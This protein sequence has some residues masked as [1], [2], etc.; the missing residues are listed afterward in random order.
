MPRAKQ[1]TPE[2][3][4]D[5]LVAALDVLSAAGPVGVTTRAVAT[6]AGTSVPALYEL[7]GDKAGLVRALFFEG[8]RR[9]GRDYAE[10]APTSDPLADLVAAV[11]TFRAFARANPR[12]FE[13]M[14]ARPFA[15]FSPGPEELATGAATRGAFVGPVQR[16]V[17]RG[18]LVGDATDIAH[19]VL[20]L[21]GGLV[22]Q[23]IAGW[24]GSSPESIERRWQ[25][26]VAAFL[27]GHRPD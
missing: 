19:G 16:A 12:L 25:A 5:L 11:E 7:F 3:R 15:E 1:R 4:A 22:T 17:D 8:F 9:L 13:V 20:A 18:L 14:Y 21:A 2:L 26:S 10:L 27:R 23:E 24:L 6:R